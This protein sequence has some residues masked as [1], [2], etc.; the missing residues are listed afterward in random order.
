[1]RT[2]VLDATSANILAALRTMSR[3]CSCILAVLATSCQSGH[4]DCDNS[5]IKAE[6]SECAFQPA[7]TVNKLKNENFC[8]SRDS[9]LPQRYE[10]LISAHTV[11]V[12]LAPTAPQRVRV[13]LHAQEFP[14]TRS[15]SDQPTMV[16][17]PQSLGLRLLHAAVQSQRWPKGK[18]GRLQRADQT[19]ASDG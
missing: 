15:H 11:L 8:A 6:P 17:S 4:N 18:R 10:R 7:C 2:S 19:R 13:S 3:C 14:Y 1:M 12:L 16:R 5:N 9:M